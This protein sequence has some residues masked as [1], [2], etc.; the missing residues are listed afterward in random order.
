MP[1][2]TDPT[3]TTL[4]CAQALLPDGWASGVRLGL[5][6]GRIAR[7]GR[8]A[9]E[10]PGDERV[11]IALPGMPNVHSHAFQRALAGLA[12]RRG[13]DAD[14]FWTWREAMYRF[15]GRLTPEDVRI[16]A[17]QAYAEMLEGGFTRVGEFHY[18][19]H[20][21]SGTPYGNI[22]EMA[23]CVAEAAGATGI[24]LTLLPCF[25]AYG[26]F[27]R[28]APSPGQARFINT[29][30]RF[31]RLMEA[32]RSAIAPLPDAVLGVAPHSLR[33]V[34]IDEIP[35]ILALSGQG[36]IHMHVAE[37]VAEVEACVEMTHRRPVALLL[38]RLRLD[39]RWCLIHATQMNEAETAALAVSGAVAGLCPLTEASLG[40]GI[41]PARSFR[42]HAGAFG[43]GTDSNIQIDAAA[44]LRQLEYGQR[45]THRE[46]NV[47][48]DGPGGSTGRALYS[49]ALA[50]GAKALGQAAPGL[51]EGAAADIVALD[52]D[53]PSLVGRFGDAV[54]DS[55][56]F[57]ARSPAIRTVW[58]FGRAVVRNGRHVD[59]AAIGAAYA[60]CL[61]RLLR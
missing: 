23:E 4:Y 13:P 41:F 1:E 5:R 11:G 16:I 17:A 12:E 40:D 27:G 31:A 55:A 46:R 15:L 39:A 24:G 45:L 19:H 43:I 38:Q 48:A 28:A 51:R 36:P 58:R 22:G 61:R 3:D 59:G 30:D 52:P 7:V 34:D 14:S 54:L 18:L 42:H 60:A 29:P 10:E 50:G 6:A 44:E 56:I 26:G 47:L 57:A 2:P 21:R 35:A 53:H 37:Q 9:T 8:D 32:S 49:A 25:Y 20:D 33:A